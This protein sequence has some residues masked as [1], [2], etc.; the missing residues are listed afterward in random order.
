MNLSAFMADG[1]NSMARAMALYVSEKH[2]SSYN[3]CYIYG[4]RGVGKSHLL[5]GIAL[6]LL[7]NEVNVLIGRISD[8]AGEKEESIRNFD[9]IIIDD[10]IFGEDNM[11]AILV[12]FVKGGGQLVLSGAK[13]P[14]VLPAS[15]LADLIKESGK[16]AD[17]SA[18]EEEL[19]VAIIKSKAHVEDIKLPHDVA[20]FIAEN[21]GS[22]ITSLIGA[23]K[24]VRAHA[25]L[26]GKEISR[27]AAIES[28]K[29][30]IWTEE[31]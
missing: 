13:S 20:H 12:D 19:K 1:S 10:F 29:D 16:S 8:K 21:M 15:P 3:P 4:A 24:R 5:N 25:S 17:I 7:Q 28:L 2:S 22:N 14:D 23:L 30:Y 31:K 18:P 6:V 27:F 11:E 26:D 9:T